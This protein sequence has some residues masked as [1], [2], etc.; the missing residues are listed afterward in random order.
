MKTIIVGGGIGGMITALYE[1]QA[2]HDVEIYE[3]KPKLGGRLAFHNRGPY[4]IDEGP[5]VVLLPQ[6][7]ND[8]LKDLNLENRIEM[9]RIDPL[10]PLHFPGGETLLKWS[11]RKKQAAEIE[12][13]FP[14]ESD[15][16]HKYMKDMEQRFEAGKPAFLDRAFLQKSS[17]FTKSNISILM[18]LKAYQSVRKQAKKYFK[19]IKLQEAFSLQTLYIGGSPLQT[20]AI[21]SLVPFSEHAH[22]IWYVKGGYGKLAEVIAEALEE[23][24]IKVNTHAFVTEVKTEKDKATG[25]VSR[26]K[27][28]PADRIILN[29]EFPFMKDLM[30]GQQKKTFQPSSG[31]LLMFF[32]LSDKINTKHV[33]NFFMG[34]SLDTHMENLF[35]KNKLDEDPA[36]YV[37]N[38]SLIDDTLAPQGHGVAYV[39]VPVPAAEHITREDYL[40]YS[41]KIKKLLI[42][43]TDHNLQDKIVWE[44]IRT[45]HEAKA[46]YL[47]EG[48][49]FGIAPSLLQSGVFRPQIKP[50]SYK[51]VYAVGAS[52]HPG[53]GIPIVMQGAKI[54]SELLR[55]EDEQVTIN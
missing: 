51:N 34:E 10:Y 19:S 27:Y 55:K 35:K 42:Q 3:A 39:L 18:K 48:G 53:G 43:R 54:L 17:F 12:R 49:S 13:I 15:S 20:S 52:V 32:G 6:M 9:L 2:G 24:N 4:K 8:I 31:C 26:N 5:T 41:E 45:P 37:F 14:G 23:R 22:G 25:I 50:F 28:I 38:P 29:G 7:I 44:H 11:D 21:Y 1:K 16:F 46:D 30:P 40:I 36:F 33:H 47:F